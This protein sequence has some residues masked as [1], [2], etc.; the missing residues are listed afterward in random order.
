VIGRTGTL[1]LSVNADSV[2]IGLGGASNDAWAL[3]EGATVLASGVAPGYI[4]N[5]EV[6]FTLQNPADTVLTFTATAG[7]VLLSSFDAPE[8]TIPEPASL[9]VLGAAL[10]GFGV[11]RRRRRS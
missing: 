9:A 11:M 2:Q 1:A 5:T 4:N 6:P 8:Q 10:I 7:N 3:M